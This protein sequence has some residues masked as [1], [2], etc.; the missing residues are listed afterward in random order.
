ME[1]FSTALLKIVSVSFLVS[2]TSIMFTYAGYQV[3]LRLEI[4]WVIGVY[5]IIITVWLAILHFVSFL[6]LKILKAK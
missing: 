3:N 6:I 2:F 5:G 4:F 1:K